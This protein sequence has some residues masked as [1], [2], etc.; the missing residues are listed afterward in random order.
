M[1]SPTL[2]ITFLVRSCFPVELKLR[3]NDSFRSWFIFGT[4]KRCTADAKRTAESGC[5][6]ST[7]GDSQTLIVCCCI[8][9]TWTLCLYY[10]NTLDVTL[11]AR[12]LGTHSQRFPPKLTPQVVRPILFG[13]FFGF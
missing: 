4:L 8:E 7:F 12:Y 13:A 9:K 6:R 2:S 1:A 5:P 11:T 3:A 10:C